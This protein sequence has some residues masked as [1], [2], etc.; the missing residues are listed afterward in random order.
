MFSVKK[1]QIKALH[2]AF[3]IM[4][5]LHALQQENNQV[6]KSGKEHP[7]Q[8]AIHTE[9]DDIISFSFGG[10]LKQCVVLVKLGIQT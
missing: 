6:I 3:F 7:T 8:R 1:L 2:S 5:C 4:H 9:Q 10:F